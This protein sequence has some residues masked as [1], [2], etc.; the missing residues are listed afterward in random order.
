MKNYPYVIA[1]L[2]DLI[3]DFEKSSHDIDA[4]LTQVSENM[5]AKDKR[6][7]DWL[8][9]GLKGEN[10]TGHFYREVFKSRN[11]FLKE[12]FRY[13]LDIRNIQVAYVAR[14][15]SSDAL[16]YITGTGALAESLLTSRA[17]DFGA[18]EFFEDS[19]RL[20]AILGGNNILDREQNIDLMRW[21]KATEIA[22]FNYFDIDYLLCFITKLMIVK[23][24]DSLDKKVGA[25]LFRKLVDEVRSTYKKEETNL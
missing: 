12:Y 8:L 1:G 10:L 6:F 22:T 14:I 24:W 3:P 7:L 5:P 2:P 15:N 16:E 21:K 23:R 18:G 20:F 11:R 19:A 13:D 25:E 17:A 9:F 4:I